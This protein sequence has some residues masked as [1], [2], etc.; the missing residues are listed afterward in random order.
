MSSNPQTA[1]ETIGIDSA[2]NNVA[3]RTL[4]GSV[5]SLVIDGDA[6][7]EYEVDIRE[8]GGTWKQGVGASYTGAS[9]YD[10]VRRTGADE[11]RVRCSSGTSG[12]GDEA[13]IG[14][15]VN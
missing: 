12:S 10:D 8:R 4:D 5:V 2:G 9:D 1:D 15:F 13:T 6:T 14:I 11:L 7:A 3:V